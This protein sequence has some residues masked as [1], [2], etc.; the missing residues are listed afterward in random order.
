MLWYKSA[1]TITSLMG[2][3]AALAS[4]T[5]LIPQARKIHKLGHAHDI[6]GATFAILSASYVLWMAYGVLL[7]DWP[8]IITNV[9]CLGLGV[10]IL[11]VKLQARGR[12]A[13]ARGTTHED[14]R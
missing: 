10:F 4:M 9:V 7:V 12:A 3:L 1:M 11:K 2:A 5:A 8:I 14:R 13:S 6:S